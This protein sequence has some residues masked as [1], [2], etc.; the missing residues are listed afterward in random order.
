[1]SLI[2]S[3]HCQAPWLA[4]RHVGGWQACWP[5]LAR[6]L[7]PSILHFSLTL[8]HAWGWAGTGTTSTYLTVLVLVLWR[9]SPGQQNPPGEK[10]KQSVTNISENV[11]KPI[12]QYM[13]QYMITHSP[14]EGETR[15]LGGPGLS[16]VGSKNK[17]TGLL[18]YL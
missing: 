2:L 15:A 1:M 14:P 17:Q 10:L 3:G 13:L 6:L 12:N 7:S 9:N 8:S 5:C 11:H 4:G 18:D 16:L